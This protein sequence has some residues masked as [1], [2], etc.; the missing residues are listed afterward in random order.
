MPSDDSKRSE[1]APRRGKQSVVEIGRH[2]VGFSVGC[3]E[4]LLFKLSSASSQ[5]WLKLGLV[6]PC[7]VC[8]ML[9]SATRVACR[10]DPSRSK[11]KRRYISC[12]RLGGLKGWPRREDSW[13]GKAPRNRNIKKFATYLKRSC[14]SRGRLH[15][16][17]VL[18]VRGRL[19][20]WCRAIP[21]PFFCVT[22]HKN[23]PAEEK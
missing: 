10:D 13:L 11:P 22:T 12:C 20:S 17:D 19:L 16:L 5:G 7:P 6:R 14:Q 23:T 3:E 18:V 15:R 8:T 1:G 4:A 2:A 21:V 9:A